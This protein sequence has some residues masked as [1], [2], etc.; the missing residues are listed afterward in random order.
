MGKRE[1][2]FWFLSHVLSSLAQGVL[3]GQDLFSLLVV[4]NSLRS[5]DCSMPGFPIYHQF[6]ELAHTHAPQ[7]SDAI[8]PSYPLSSSSLP[9]FS[10]SQHQGL[11][12]WVTAWH[13]YWP[14]YWNFSFNISPFN[15]YSGLISFRMDWLDLLTV[16]GT[17]NSRLQHHSSKVSVLWH[18]AFFYSPTLTSMH[19]CWKNHSFD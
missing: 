4:S 19:D 15:E 1:P 13:Q 9:A 12:Q 7:V 17:L 5:L 3:A 16:Q 11:F 14:K 2:G 10:L 8:H 6:P 18:S